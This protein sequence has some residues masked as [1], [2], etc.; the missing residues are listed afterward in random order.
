MKPILFNNFLVSTERI[1]LLNKEITQKI[2][3]NLSLFFITKKETEGKVCFA[4]SNEVRAE[5]KETFTQIDLN[6]YIYAV[7]HSSN[8][9]GT[10]PDFSKVDLLNIPIPT[11]RDKFWKLIELGKGLSEIHLFKNKNRVLND[12]TRISKQIDAIMI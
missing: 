8:Y 4:N 5:F 9:K 6:Y 2:S 11:D 10:D 12:V 3:N 7:L 1:P